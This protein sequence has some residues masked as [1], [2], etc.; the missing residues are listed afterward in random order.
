MKKK[1]N[2]I[3]EGTCKKCPFCQFNSLYILGGDLGY[4]CIYPGSE[5]GRVV[6]NEEIRKN[7][8]SKTNGWPP[9]PDN[10]SLPVKD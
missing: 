9:I 8:S 2:L 6:N 3:I 4:D 10:C 5:V 7:F 1:I